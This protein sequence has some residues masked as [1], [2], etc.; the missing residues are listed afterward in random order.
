MSAEHAPQ[1]AF[2]A[3]V[4]EVGT[5]K[6]CWYCQFV[7]TLTAAPRGGFYWTA[8][9]DKVD[10]GRHCLGGLTP[11]NAYDTIPHTYHLPL[12]EMDEDRNVVGERWAHWYSAEGV[13]RTV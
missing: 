13:G 6:V 7:V 3:P 4:P 9:R 12:P 2:Y 10:G 11:A 8:G 1:P 5:Q